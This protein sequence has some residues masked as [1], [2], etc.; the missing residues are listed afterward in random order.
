[1]DVGFHIRAVQGSTILNVFKHTHIFP[2]GICNKF[3]SVNALLM[4]TECLSYTEHCFKNSIIC[5]NSNMF[6]PHNNLT[7]KLR[8]RMT[9]QPIVLPTTGHQFI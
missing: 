1:M 8:C 2:Y 4:H 6:K 3:I 9:P 7:K 5:L